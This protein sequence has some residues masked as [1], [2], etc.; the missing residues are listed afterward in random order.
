MVPEVTSCA[1][2]GPCATVNRDTTKPRTRILG[3]IVTPPFIRCT[4]PNQVQDMLVAF[5]GQSSIGRG[6]SQVM[7]GCFHHPRRVGYPPRSSPQSGSGGVSVRPSTPRQH[8]KRH[9]A[10]NGVI[11]LHNGRPFWMEIETV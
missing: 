3:R 11:E 4:A 10:R 2:A 5:F 1:V 8:L 7:T 6:T 9:G